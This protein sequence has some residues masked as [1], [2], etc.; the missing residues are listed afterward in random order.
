MGICMREFGIFKADDDSAFM[1]RPSLLFQSMA[2]IAAKEGAAVP[3]SI[4][5]FVGGEDLDLKTGTSNTLSLRDYLRD[6]Q[7]KLQ[8]ILNAPYGLTTHQKD[9][10]EQV[11]G[12]D[13]AEVRGVSMV[14]DFNQFAIHK[15]RYFSGDPAQETR[16]W[17]T[18]RREDQEKGHA[19]LAALWNHR[20]AQAHSILHFLPQ[21]RGALVL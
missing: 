16:L 4:R 3:E 13:N 19:N 5:L 18:A 12:F 8:V 1:V 15:D 21:P 2:V 9:L 6:G 20:W 10:L 14:A 11:S 7:N 17:V